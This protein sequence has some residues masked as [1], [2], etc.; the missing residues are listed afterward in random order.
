MRT[1]MALCVVAIVGFVGV[2]GGGASPVAKKA[3][4]TITYWPDEQAP[5][6]Y[7][8]WTLRCNPVG[9]TLPNR[10]R[11]C[12]RLSRLPLSSF[13]QVPK[14]AICTQIYGGPQKAVVKGTIGT[15]RIWSSFRRRNGCEIERW[16]R[17]SPW[18][19]PSG[20]AAR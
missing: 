14:D 3:S 19:F 10:V 15:V 20:G 11:A 16:N 6:T 17:F 13:A 8:R 18:L 4:L 12:T 5:E 9:G 2:A 1:L 7:Q